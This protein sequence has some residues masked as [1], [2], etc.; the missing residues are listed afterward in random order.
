MLSR[1]EHIV[2]SIGFPEGRRS[3]ASFA[4]TPAAA[5]HRPLHLLA[6]RLSWSFARNPNPHILHPHADCHVRAVAKS[7]VIRKL[8]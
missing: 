7:L 4:P 1:R 8:T 3:I 6:R 5:H 2:V